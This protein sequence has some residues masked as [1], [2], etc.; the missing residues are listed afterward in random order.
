MRGAAGMLLGCRGWSG[1]Q[2]RSGVGWADGGDSSDGGGGAGGSANKQAASVR[3][4]MAARA[5]AGVR[6]QPLSGGARGL[7]LRFRY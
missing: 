1:G 4:A 7:H 2:Q 3:A 6:E 5:A